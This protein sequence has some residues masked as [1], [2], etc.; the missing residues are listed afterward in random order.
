MA[1]SLCFRAAGDVIKDEGDR[2]EY[3]K[4]EGAASPGMEAAPGEDDLYE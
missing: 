1:S 2:F 3:L 4:G